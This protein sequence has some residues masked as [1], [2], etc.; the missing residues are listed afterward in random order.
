L[1]HTLSPGAWR[2]LKSTSTSNHAFAILAF[3][4]RGNYRKLL[5]TEATFEDAA[6]I[7]QDVV[8]ALAPHASA[9]LLDPEYGLPAALSMSGQSGLLMALEKTG[10]G[11]DSTYR[12]VD[13][14]DG[15]TVEKIKQMGASAVK[16][17]IY[18]HPQSGALAEEIENCIRAVAAHC[19]K[20]ELPLFVEPLAYSLEPNISRDSAEF[21]E[22]LPSI[23][24]ETARRLSHCGATILKLEFP[25]N[26]K[27]DRDHEHWRQACAE[28]TEV[29]QVP[30]AL[31]SAGVDFETFAQQLTIACQVGCSGFLGGRAIWKECI[32]MT[33]DERLRFLNTK[34]VDRLAKL[35]QIT[36]EF[37]RPWTDFYQAVGWG[38]NWYESYAEG[39]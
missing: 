27:F 39:K 22:Q 29:C 38:E 1:T 37:A 10:Y 16:L 33:A 19:Q 20:H 25:I 32:G 17:L 35:T 5:P 7:K 28:I 11:G 14:I 6:R 36:Q 18:Y 31:L 12:Q 26:P 4:Q 8:A 9:V 15:W 21:A 3:D 2:G 13:F 30:W 24:S 34:G 23:V